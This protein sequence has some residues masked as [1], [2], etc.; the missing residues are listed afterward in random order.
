M[1]RWKSRHLFQAN[2]GLNMVNQSLNFSGN[3]YSITKNLDL[4]YVFCREN[5]VRMMGVHT[6]DDI[7][8]KRDYDLVPAQVANLHYSSDIRVIKGVVVINEHEVLVS[9]VEVVPIIVSKNQ[10]LDRK[11]HCKGVMLSFIAIPENIQKHFL[12]AKFDAEGKR[13]QFTIDDKLEYFT[14]PRPVKSTGESTCSS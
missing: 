14:F 3:V 6:S 10:V 5:F 11:G 2:G 4:D 7:I 12:R 13:Y 1:E 8:G 9:E